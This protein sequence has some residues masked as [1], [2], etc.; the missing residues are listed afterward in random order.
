MS[1]NAAGIGITNPNEFAR[2][3]TATVPDFNPHDALGLNATS[4]A[5]APTPH[6]FPLRAEVNTARVDLLDVAA[7]ASHRERGAFA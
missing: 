6:A 2:R 3:G 7:R 5:P 1:N 4:S